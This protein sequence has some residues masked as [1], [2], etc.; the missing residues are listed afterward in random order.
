MS[1]TILA[2]VGPQ[3]GRGLARQLR[4]GVQ[5][6]MRSLRHTMAI[7]TS[8]RASIRRSP[9]CQQRLDEC[10][11][12]PVDK[13]VGF[14]AKRDLDGHRVGCGD[15]REASP[16]RTGRA[17]WQPWPP[18]RVVPL[19]RPQVWWLV[20]TRSQPPTW[21]TP[22]SPPVYLPLQRGRRTRV[23]RRQPS[24]RRRILHPSDN[25]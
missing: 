6:P 5:G 21:A 23:L 19:S 24:V 14:R 16:S 15:T 2:S 18:Y 10:H 7:P 3:P 12:C 1:P 22:T 9:G 11:L 13:P 20:T 25:Q 8:P 4:P 17:S